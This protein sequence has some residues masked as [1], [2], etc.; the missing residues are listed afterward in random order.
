MVKGSFA[1]SHP[2]AGPMSTVEVTLLAG[3]SPALPVAQPAL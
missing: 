2:K 3:P 1:P